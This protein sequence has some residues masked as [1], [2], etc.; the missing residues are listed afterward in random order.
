MA[1]LE[2]EVSLPRLFSAP[3]AIAPIISTN[4]PFNKSQTVVKGVESK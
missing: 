1:M 2:A 3:S 4:A